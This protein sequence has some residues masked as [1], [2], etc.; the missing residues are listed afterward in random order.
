MAAVPMPG[1]ALLRS[2]Y[3]SPAMY[4]SLE[5][6]DFTA[7]S[8]HDSKSKHDNLFSMFPTHSK[9]ILDKKSQIKE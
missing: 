8:K 6:R 5:P 9:P 4:G 7:N 3:L 1:S 2:T